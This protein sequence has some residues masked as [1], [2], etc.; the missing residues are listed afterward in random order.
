MYNVK[1]CLTYFMFNLL[2]VAE[3]VDNISNEDIYSLCKPAVEGKNAPQISPTV[4][5]AKKSVRK[6]TNTS[7]VRDLGKA[8][9]IF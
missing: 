3:T 8:Q 4:K 7:P 1:Y 6:Q 9:F 2:F 5:K